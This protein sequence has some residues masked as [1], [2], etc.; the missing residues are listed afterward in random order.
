MKYTPATIA[1][2]LVSG[3]VAFIGAAAAGAHGADLSTLGVGEWLFALSAGA[4][5]AGTVFVTPNKQQP[6]DT[7]E[8]AEP[9]SP[10]PPIADVAIG[11]VQQTAQNAAHGMAEL[12]RVMQAARD[13]IGAEGALTNTPVPAVPDGWSLADNLADQVMRSVLPNQPRT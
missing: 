1:K 3:V 7:A 12:D 5:A 13:I 4:T 9:A 10:P 2:S 6:A 8:T 11:A